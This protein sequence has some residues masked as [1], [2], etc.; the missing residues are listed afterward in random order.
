M[1]EISRKA[2]C[3]KQQAA[4]ICTELV[5]ESVP[6]SSD[7]KFFMR[8]LGLLVASKG[9]GEED[10]YKKY[11]TQLK[12]ESASRLVAIIYDNNSLDLKFWLQYGR[13]PFLGQ[14]FNDKL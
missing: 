14:K 10:K 5:K 8:M 12:E 6:S 7:T 11:L 1:L 2:N 9:S 3:T 13:K 4:T